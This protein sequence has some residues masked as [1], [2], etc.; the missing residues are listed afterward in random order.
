MHSKAV[1][2]LITVKSDY[3]NACSSM[4]NVVIEALRN[5]LKSQ[6]EKI[7]NLIKSFT[8][9]YRPVTSPSDGGTF[10]LVSK[11]RRL[12]GAES[13]TPKASTT[14]RRKHQVLSAIETPK[15]PSGVVYGEGVSEFY[16]FGQSF[17]G[18]WWK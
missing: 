13:A 16:A 7:Q 6:S 17:Y 1:H 9:W 8:H 4:E 2:T 12:R 3:K 10:D 5:T 11:I 18:L 15:A 14:R